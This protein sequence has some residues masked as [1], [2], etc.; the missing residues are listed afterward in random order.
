MRNISDKEL[1]ELFKHA[2]EHLEVTF[3]PTAWERFESMMD[4]PGI[5]GMKKSITPY[6]SMLI[7]FTGAFIWWHSVPQEQT[8]RSATSHIVD[9][10]PIDGLAIEEGFPM[11]IDDNE[12]QRIEY[13]RSFKAGSGSTEEE[14]IDPALFMATTNAIAVVEKK[15]ASL[16]DMGKKIPQS[17]VA[18]PVASLNS[19][20]VVPVTQNR[21]GEFRPYFSVG[22]RASPDFSGTGLS[23]FSKTGNSMGISLE[24]HVTPRL[25]FSTGM[26]RARK[27]YSVTDGFNPDKN[28][29]EY[30]SKPDLIDGGCIVLDI[31]VNIR[32]NLIMGERSNIFVST[33]ISSYLM[34]R[35]NYN[36]IYYSYQKDYEIRNQNNH[37]F[38]ILNLSGGYDRFIGRNWSI[39]IEPFLKMPL[40][41][42]GYG[43]LKLMS[44]G[45]F[46]SLNYH[47]IRKTLK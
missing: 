38:G 16:K 14:P 1:D 43:N 36:Y 15:A 22:L 39:G 34:T 20:V 12:K 42:I 40:S 32:Y 21:F 17:S 24:Y 25:S 27:L 8:F 45:M 35:E 4:K 11:T 31:P 13:H 9:Q 6:L 5:N 3:N 18:K 30:K 10:R 44:T 47:F 46:V 37:F 28:Y 19:S 2:A 29:W 41:E 7:I 33:G 23:A 26:T